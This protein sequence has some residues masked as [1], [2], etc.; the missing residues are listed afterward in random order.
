M[1]VLFWKM[2]NNNVII[3]KWFWW[4]FV[5]TNQHH[6]IHKYDICKCN[7]IS[8]FKCLYQSKRILL[9]NITNWKKSNNNNTVNIKKEKVQN[10]LNSTHEQSWYRCAMAFWV[11]QIAT[12]TTTTSTTWSNWINVSD[13]FKFENFNSWKKRRI[14][15]LWPENTKN[16]NNKNSF[17]LTTSRIFFR[18]K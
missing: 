8:N 1:L 5:T 15:C 6:Y 12:T 14:F 3:V 7:F 17:Q 10:R 2:N 4:W 11:F 13:T 18:I 16:N 9:L